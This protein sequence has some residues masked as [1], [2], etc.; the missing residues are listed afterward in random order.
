MF[1]T[2]RQPFQIA[3]W[4]VLGQLRSAADA[5]AMATSSDGSIAGSKWR[6]VAD[7]GIVQNVYPSILNPQASPSRKENSPAGFKRASG[8][9]P[10]PLAGLRADQ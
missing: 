2:N 9:G 3:T 10:D 5:R 8:R 4:R 1:A 6:P 7:V